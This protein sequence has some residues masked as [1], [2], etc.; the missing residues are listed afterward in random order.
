LEEARKRRE[1]EAREWQRRLQNSL[2]GTGQD[3]AGQR[4][5][6]VGPCASGK[7]ALVEFLRQYG[8]NAHAAAQE[9]SYVPK[10]WTMTSPSHLIYLE[11]NLENIK[12][13]RKISWG[14][15]YLQEENRRLAHA[16]IHAD[17][18]LDTNDLNVEDVTAQALNFLVTR[19]VSPYYSGPTINQ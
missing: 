1:V 12:R 4:I 6:V 2:D 5:V 18:I 10:M 8:Y 13:R 14:E 16:R 17:I 7:S 9:H 19:A 11:V 15:A 3:V